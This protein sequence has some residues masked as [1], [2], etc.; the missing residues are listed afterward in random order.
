MGFGNV[1]AAGGAVD[2]NIGFVSGA[3][4]R[5]RALRILNAEIIEGAVQS[6]LARRNSTTCNLSTL[7]F[8]YRE[9]RAPC[10]WTVFCCL[11][12]QSW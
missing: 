11:V 9:S 12:N 7:P 4:E 2:H 1:V 8:T 5:N 6:L 3:F 10:D